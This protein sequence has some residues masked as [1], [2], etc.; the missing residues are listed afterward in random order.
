[1]SQPWQ[2]TLANLF[3]TMTPAQIQN[4]DPYW[5]EGDRGVHDVTGNNALRFRDYTSDGHPD[6][7]EVT[8]NAGLSAGTAM[9]GNDRVG[10]VSSHIT[11]ADVT[12]NVATAHNFKVPDGGLMWNS[13]PF[14]SELNPTSNMPPGLA[15]A[16]DLF[17]LGEALVPGMASL[18]AVQDALTE[19]QN[20][21]G[22]LSV[23]GDVDFSSPFAAYCSLAPQKLMLMNFGTIMFIQLLLKGV[24][25]FA[26]GDPIGIPVVL[27]PLGIAVAALSTVQTTTGYL[28]AVTGTVLGAELKA[29]LMSSVPG[30]GAAFA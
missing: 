8:L 25:L 19:I 23:D 9:I 14:N 21:V 11:Y 7:Q 28:P 5:R 29:V 20:Q 12:V 24:P 6:R 15:Q 16:E 3:N 1:M 30:I 27:N 2:L 4:R 22:D 10:D 26:V 18:S 13:V 17:T